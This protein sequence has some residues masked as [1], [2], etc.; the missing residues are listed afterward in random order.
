MRAGDYR[1]ANSKELVKDMISNMQWASSP[2]DQ[3]HARDQVNYALA[4]GAIT[5]AQ[6]D[7]AKKA[8]GKKAQTIA[9]RGARNPASRIAPPTKRDSSKAKQNPGRL[10]S[11]NKLTRV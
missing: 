3:A 6:A 10:R 9:P 11:L 7:R 2:G 4:G 5:S 1:G 8:I